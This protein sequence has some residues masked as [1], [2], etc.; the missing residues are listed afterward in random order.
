[1]SFRCRSLW[2]VETAGEALLMLVVI[3]MD[4]ALKCSQKERQIRWALL[5]GWLLGG[6]RGAIF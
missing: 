4:I 6:V 3:V 1:M 2:V 5:L